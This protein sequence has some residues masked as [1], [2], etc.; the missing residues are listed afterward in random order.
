MS[1]QSEIGADILDARDVVE[2]YQRWRVSDELAAIEES[3]IDFEELADDDPVLIH[4][5]YFEDYA[6]ELAEDIG[7]IDKGASWPNTYIDW[8]A[9]S[10]ALKMDYTAYEI[11]GH[12]YWGR[13]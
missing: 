12:T 8:E 7:A 10:N 9:A 2:G 11:A 3:N 4:D 5:R 1:W 13:S 6:R